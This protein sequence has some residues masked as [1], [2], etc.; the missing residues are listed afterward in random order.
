MKRKKYIIG[1]KFEDAGPLNT[2]ASPSGGDSTIGTESEESNVKNISSN[3][4]IG[5]AISGGLG[6]VTSGV[7]AYKRLSTL[8]GQED[9]IQELKDVKNASG[10][11]GQLNNIQSLDDLANNFNF[12]KTDYNANLTG[13]MGAGEMAGDIIGESLMQ[14]AQG[15]MAGMS[16]GGPWGALI[17]GIIGGVQGTATSVAGTVV[18]NQRA[19]TLANKLNAEG[20]AANKRLVASINDRAGNITLNNANMARLNMAA[21]GG[22]LHSGT[23]DNGVRFITEGNSH[24]KNPYGGVLQGIATDGLPNLVEEGEVIYNDYVYSKRLNVPDKDKEALGLKKNKTY[25]YADAAEVLQRESEERPNDALSK[26]NLEAM[27]LRLQ[28][29]QEQLKQQR[30]KRK[31]NRDF[32]KLTPAEQMGFVMGLQQEQQ[33]PQIAPQTSLPQEYA[34]GG[35]LGHEYSGLKWDIDGN[36]LTYANRPGY[37]RDMN[38]GDWERH[39]YDTYGTPS[40][41]IDA[42]T[43]LLSD[44]YPNP[45]PY[46]SRNISIDKYG[47]ATVGGTPADKNVSAFP[48]SKIAESTTYPN[49]TAVSANPTN[50]VYEIKPSLELQSRIKLPSRPDGPTYETL[51]P[52]VKAAIKQRSDDAYMSWLVRDKLN[53]SDLDES[54]DDDVQN[55]E[56]KYSSGAQAL[57]AMPVL[58]S[59]IGALT[60]LFDKPDYSTMQ[61]T[62]NKYEAIPHVSATP[63]GERLTFNPIDVNY[64]ATQM[65]NQGIGARRAAME[66]G[67]GYS[68]PY[69]IYQGQ[70]ALGDMFTKAIESDNRQ[71]QAIGE[72]NRQTSMFNSQQALAAAQA[73]MQRGAALAHGYLQTGQLRNEELGKVQAARSLQF[74]KMF[75][76]LGAL[77]QDMLAREMN[78]WLAN[79]GV[80]GTGAE[81]LTDTIGGTRNRIKQTQGKKGG[82]NA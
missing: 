1:H 62:E 5:A 61:R 12:A 49:D 13:K 34:K 52:D 21:F 15:A 64:I 27:M 71:R 23:F 14:S 24:E 18:R 78:A 40:T 58:G 39:M 79:R 31:F 70:T 65:N 50:N 26:R 32:N 47:N 42:Y 59:T 10:T 4:N 56:F 80:Y 43:Q 74:T 35:T 48:S 55:P 29:S 54:N 28:D 44:A 11:V 30:E 8:P 81:E 82:S 57:R 19:Q 9:K 66:S 25:T 53:V 45:I 68:T 22:P 2:G 33:Q 36:A 76:N 69:N 17:G 77:G 63:I 46:V 7:N 41:I 60:S 20:E 16:A 72:F 67:A 3:I 51:T 75:D 37:Y 73:E 6:L 38:E